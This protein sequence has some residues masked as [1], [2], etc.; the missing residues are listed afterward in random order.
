MDKKFGTPERHG[1]SDS[2]HLTRNARLHG[3]FP[4]P[5]VSTV[6]ALS[7]LYELGTFFGPF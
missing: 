6:T 2:A 5:E 4:V 7:L 1:R 3:G